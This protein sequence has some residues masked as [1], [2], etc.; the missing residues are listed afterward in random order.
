MTTRHVARAA[1]DA[2]ANTPH[3]HVEIRTGAHTLAADEPSDN[4]GRDTGPSPFGL[5]ISALASC[6][7][8]TLRMYA[9]RKGWTLASIEVD[10]R[11]NIGDDDTASIERTIAFPADLPAEQRERLVEI[12][13]RTPVTIAV[14]RDTPSRRPSRHDRARR[15]RSLLRLA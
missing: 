15:H 4:G 5:L 14:R 11:Y 1:A 7:A 3:W 2:S 12:A 13:E 10:A 9:E 6:T 8:M